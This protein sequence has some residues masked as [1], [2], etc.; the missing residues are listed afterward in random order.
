MR[1]WRMRSGTG[2]DSRSRCL[3]KVN[4]NASSVSAQSAGQ[5]MHMGNLVPVI[6]IYETRFIQSIDCTAIDQGGS[7]TQQVIDSV[8]DPAPNRVDV[9]AL[10]L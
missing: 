9:D 7:A 8:V 10:Y 4:F 1:F 3:P 6:G 2:Y 5:Y